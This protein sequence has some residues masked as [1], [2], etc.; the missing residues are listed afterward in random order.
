[1]TTYYQE[2]DSKIIFPVPAEFKYPVKGSK[3]SFLTT[4]F[5]QATILG[6]GDVTESRTSKSAFRHLLKL[7]NET[8]GKKPFLNYFSPTESRL[9]KPALETLRNTQNQE[10]AVKA[11]K[12]L[13]DLRETV[14]SFQQLG[15][16]L[17]FLPPIRAFNNDDGSV[18]VEW[19]FTDFRIGFSI[20]TILDE[21]GWYLVSKRNLGEISASGFIENANIKN[22]ILWLLNFVISHS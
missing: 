17:T 10:V 4:R 19:I 18:L 16:D 8:F 6:G 22:I 14:S 3:E 15:F 20:E 12:I 7:E 1:M 13:E 11:R 9:I 5:D 2:T 21:S